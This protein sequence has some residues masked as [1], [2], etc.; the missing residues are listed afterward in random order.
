MSLSKFYKTNAN[1]KPKAV[2][3]TTASSSRAPVWG[4]I[5]KDETVVPETV[6]EVSEELSTPDTSLSD[7]V[8][9]NV[10]TTEQS[11]EVIVD[12]THTTLPEETPA[13]ATPPEPAIDIDTIRENAFTSGIA[14]GRQ[15][16]EEDFENIA[17]TLLSVCNELD[18]LRELILQNS[19]DEM[20]ELV[21]AISE[22]IIRHSVQEQE[23]T[24]I[25]TIK[26]AIHLA[27]KSDEFQI[28]INPEDLA[29]VTSKKSE[30]INSISG[31]D[32]IV[33]KSDPNIERGGCKLESTCC[34][35]DASMASQIKV[36]HDSIMAADTLQDQKIMNTPLNPKSQ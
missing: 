15:Q 17:Q 16:A 28:Q 5:I 9:E 29:V 27:V 3:D 6:S 19:A 2:L 4:S 35:V 22:R 8:S 7:I 10:Q 26:D 34:T 32:N 13:Q 31:L 1:F 20:K 33:L 25:A 30:I 11:T 24:I 14:A 23:D 18:R 12:D 36:I 21:L